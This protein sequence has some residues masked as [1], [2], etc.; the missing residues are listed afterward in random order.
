MYKPVCE[1]HDATDVYW[2][3]SLVELHPNFENIINDSEL[4]IQYLTDENCYDEVLWLDLENL[5]YFILKN[6]IRFYFSRF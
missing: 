6:D 4:L 2:T 3:K 1:S 5:R